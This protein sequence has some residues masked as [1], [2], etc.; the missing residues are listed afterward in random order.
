MVHEPLRITDKI[1]RV[2][3]TYYHVVLD[4][5]RDRVRKYQRI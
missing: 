1:L 3:R 4:N 2:D 5:Y